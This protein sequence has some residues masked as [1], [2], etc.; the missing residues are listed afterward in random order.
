MKICRSLDWLMFH[1]AFDEL[2]SH[3]KQKNRSIWWRGNKT[4]PRLF[5]IQKQCS[6]K[7]WGYLAKYLTLKWICVFIN[8]WRISMIFRRKLTNWSSFFEQVI[9]ATIKLRFH[10]QMAHFNLFFVLCEK[11]N[12]FNHRLQSLVFHFYKLLETAG[13]V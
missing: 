6:H 1:F 11:R 12:Y 10:Q 3:R 13:T 5:K 2:R 9:K 8:R 7:R 4:M